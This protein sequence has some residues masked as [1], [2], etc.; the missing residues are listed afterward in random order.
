MSRT[1]SA[2]TRKT[3]WSCFRPRTEGIVRKDE[4]AEECS[5]ARGRARASADADLVE[6]LRDGKVLGPGVELIGVLLRFDAGDDLVRHAAKALAEQAE[7]DPPCG[8]QFPFLPQHVGAGSSHGKDL[9]AQ[10]VGLHRT[11]D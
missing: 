2:V 7:Q 9:L 8:S 10:L 4:S 3:T 1:P 6:P 11:Q 5:A